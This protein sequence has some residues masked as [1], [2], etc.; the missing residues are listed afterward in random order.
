MTVIQKYMNNNKR[1]YIVCVDLMKCF[2]T[3]YRNGLWLKL[4]KY[5]I[6]GKLLRIIRDNMKTLN[7]V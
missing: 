5:G 1:L 7:L 2:D 4:H 6:Q 3:I